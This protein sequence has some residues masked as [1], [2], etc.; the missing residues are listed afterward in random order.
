MFAG[1]YSLEIPTPNIQ[2][3]KAQF[4]VVGFKSEEGE[5]VDLDNPVNSQAKAE[6]WFKNIL[7]EMRKTLKKKFHDAENKI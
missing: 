6:E 2:R 3:A 7:D 5:K 4:S 1:I